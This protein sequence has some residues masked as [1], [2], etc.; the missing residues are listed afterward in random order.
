[1]MNATISAAA[2]R[3]ETITHNGKVLCLIVRSELRAKTVFHTSNDIN[4]QV[5]HI[6]YRAGGEVQRHRHPPITRTVVGHAE[7]VIVE[8]GR[9]HF[10]VYSEEDGQLLCTREV[11]PRDIVV[12]MAGGHGYRMIEDTVLIE[13]K[14]GPFSGVPEKILF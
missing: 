13:V 8:S 12:V 9:A 6:V 11:G 1:M 3:T 5:G 4:L 7:V 10:D 2:E 14:Q